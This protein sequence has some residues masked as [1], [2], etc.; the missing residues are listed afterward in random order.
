MKQLLR[1]VCIA[2]LAVIGVNQVTF[3]QSKA[4]QKDAKKESKK[5]EKEGWTMLTGSGTM[6]YANL[7]FRT[8]CEENDE[9]VP[10]YGLAEGS[11]VKIGTQNAT[12]SALTDYAS[13]ASSQ[14]VGKMKGLGMANNSEGEIDETDKFGAAYEVAVK[15]KIQGLVKTHFVLVKS[16]NGRKMFRAYLSINESEARKAREKAAEE[17]RVSVNMKSLSDDVKDFI[18]ESVT[19]D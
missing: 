12:F 9:V 5:W 11:N 1:I 8:L 16:D 2:C 19:I 3:A 17:A 7:K 14:V 15:K 4:L 10:L 18:G 6:E 13:K